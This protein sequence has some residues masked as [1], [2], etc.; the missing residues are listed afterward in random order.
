MSEYELRIESQV[1]KEL[2]G[3]CN[4]GELQTIRGEKFKRTFMKSEKRKRERVMQLTNAWA[5]LWCCKQETPS[6][7]I[8]L[9]FFV[10]MKENFKI[11]ALL[12]RNLI[13]T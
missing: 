6:L 7:D 1:Y 4:K 8:N 3:E 9:G 10:A 2:R 13:I 12:S 5:A 11:C